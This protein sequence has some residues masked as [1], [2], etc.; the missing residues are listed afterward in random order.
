MKH[1]TLLP[2][3]V[4]HTMFTYIIHSK[5]NRKYVLYILIAVSDTRGTNFCQW[6][7]WA[8]LWTDKMK[9]GHAIDLH[10]D[11]SKMLWTLERS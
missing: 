9:Q 10:L 8:C 5:I 6:T 7:K 4:L 3:Q 1:A 11:A 2:E